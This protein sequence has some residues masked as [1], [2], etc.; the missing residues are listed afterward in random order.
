MSFVS[1][2]YFLMG[3][4]HKTAFIRKELAAPGKLIKGLRGGA[5][6]AVMG[7]LLAPAAAYVA[8]DEDDMIRAALLGSLGG[9]VGGVAREFAI[10][11]LAKDT[12]KGRVIGNLI[13]GVPA[14][15]TSIGARKINQKIKK[16]LA[17]RRKQERERDKLGKNSLDG[18]E[19]A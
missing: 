3:Y 7:G 9:S 6:G 15:G 10:P 17:K 1:P 19:F 16:E 5:G 18:T 12:L 11:Y 2:D 14:F 4:L 8:G 13:I